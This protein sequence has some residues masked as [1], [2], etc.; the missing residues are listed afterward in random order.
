[1]SKEKEDK[2]RV[3]VNA[4]ARRSVTQSNRER[5]VSVETCNND[6]DAP[7]MMILMRAQTV[8]HS[9]VRTLLGGANKT[10]KGVVARRLMPFRRS[11]VGYVLHTLLNLFDQVYVSVQ[12]ILQP[13]PAI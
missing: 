4:R 9:S 13:P 12:Q 3:S 8:Q 1:M 10:I 11:L 5:I 6:G 7:T 2:L